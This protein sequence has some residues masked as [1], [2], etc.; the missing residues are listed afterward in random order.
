MSAYTLGLRT[1]K[2]EGKREDR[3]MTMGYRYLSQTLADGLSHHTSD[4]GAVYGA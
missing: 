1:T 4:G 2:G 3:T